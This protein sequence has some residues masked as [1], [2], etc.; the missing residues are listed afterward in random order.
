V[1]TPTKKCARFMS[2]TEVAKYIGLSDVTSMSRYKLPP[3]DAVVGTHRGWLKS[4]IDEW[5]LS[6][7]GPGWH[8]ARDDPRRKTRSR[9]PRVRV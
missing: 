8:G 2:R 7:P 6:R 4:T 9:S 1:V 3:P 5:N